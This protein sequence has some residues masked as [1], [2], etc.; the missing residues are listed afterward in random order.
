M[1]SHKNASVAILHF[2]CTQNNT[3]SELNTSV[4]LRQHLQVSKN[5]SALQRKKTNKKN[6]DST[7]HGVNGHTH[8]VVAKNNFV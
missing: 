8:I 2:R 5:G 7:A 1:S 3:H 4:I 6:N